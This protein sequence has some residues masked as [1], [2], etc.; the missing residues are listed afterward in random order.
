MV[1]SSFEGGIRQLADGG[2][3]DNKHIGIVEAKS[4]NEKTSLHI[5]SVCFC[6]KNA[7][8]N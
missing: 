6:I 3:L 1:I 4:K 2:C 8:P 5:V 7:K